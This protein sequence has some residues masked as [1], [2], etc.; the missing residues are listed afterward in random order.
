M[1]FR[2][3]VVLLAVISCVSIG[4][5]AKYAFGWEIMTP[6]VF[7]GLFAALLARQPK[8]VTKEK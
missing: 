2:L 1:N 7:G 3:R 4:A 8:K 5:L 6:M